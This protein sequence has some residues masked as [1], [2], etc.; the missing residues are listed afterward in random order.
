MIDK[1]KWLKWL[2]PRLPLPML[3]L[4]ASYGV[5]QFALLFVPQWVAVVQAASFEATYIGLATIEAESEAQKRRATA[6][7]FGA[8]VVSVLYNW[9]AGFF[10]R[11]P[12]TLIG[13]SNYQ[14]AGLAFLH[15][16]PLAIVAYLVADLLLHKNQ[17][18]ADDLSTEQPIVAT[19][20]L[21]APKPALGSLIDDL[22]QDTAPNLKAAS[23]VVAPPEKKQ[24]RVVGK[25]EKSSKPSAESRVRSVLNERGNME[26]SELYEVFPDIPQKSLRIYVSTWRKENL[27]TNGSH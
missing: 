6:I 17:Q 1:L 24:K 14:E 7:S 15:G 13:L 12:E 23:D 20:A 22:Q 3:A 10:H 2:L 27:T 26:V 19:P 16:A 21:P 25:R 11:N 9:L 18:R 5:Y 4:S 8:V